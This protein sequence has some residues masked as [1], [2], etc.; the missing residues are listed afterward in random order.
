MAAAE[1]SGQRIIQTGIICPFQ[2]VGK[3]GMRFT[4]SGFK[5]F[6]TIHPILCRLPLTASDLFTHSCV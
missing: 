5:Q 6:L 3:S 4:P 1:H 2:K